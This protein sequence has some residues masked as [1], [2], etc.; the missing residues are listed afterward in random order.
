MFDAVLNAAMC[1]HN[2]PA[3]YIKIDV[4]AYITDCHAWPEINSLFSLN[5]IHTE[6][7]Q[8]YQKGNTAINALSPESKHEK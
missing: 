2:S 7:F 5:I 6:M 1:E 3:I 4:N 8:I